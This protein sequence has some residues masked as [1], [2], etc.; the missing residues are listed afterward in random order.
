MDRWT[1]SPVKKETARRPSFA[2][3]AVRSARFFLA[4]CAPARFWIVKMAGENRQNENLNHFYIQGLIPVKNGI[5][6]I[7][8]L[9]PFL[10]RALPGH[11][12]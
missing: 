5:G 12:S 11:R 2:T 7:L 1:A 8:I 4:L 3:A 6:L 9:I 10:E